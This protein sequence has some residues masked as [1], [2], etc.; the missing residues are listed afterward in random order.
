VSGLEVDLVAE[1]GT[2]EGEPFRLR[3]SFRTGG[4]ITVVFGPSGAGKSTLLLSVLGALRPRSGRI[5]LD[6]RVL[7][8]AAA[9]VDLPVRR[10]RIGVVFQDALLFPHLDA[11]AN[12]AFGLEGPERWRL[13]DE[14]LGRVDGSSLAR[15]RP[16]EMSGGERQRVAVARALAPRPDALLLDEPFSAL[17]GP[18]RAAL[19][20]LLRSLQAE[21]GIPFLHVTHDPVEALRLGSEMVVLERGAVA[22]VGPPGPVLGA[23]RWTEGDNLF[24]GVVLRHLEA[25]GY[26]SVDLGGTVVETALLAAPPGE[27]VVLRLAPEDILLS[28]RAVRETS[29][30]NVIA[31]RVE[32]LRPHAAGVEVRV[33]TPVVFR[34][35]LT[36]G[37]IRELGLAPGAPVHL[38]VKAY[39]FRS[40]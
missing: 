7:F 27:R 19:G 22:Q 34:A 24:A 4:G 9:R 35:L 12:V 5:A 40:A 10:R 1:R 31:G 8:D 15:R 20:S 18:S 36:H 13:A 25:E 23:A 38:L 39:S 32:E 3:V 2:Q 29:A 14:V 21:S 11:R 17:D 30:R 26:T 33:S 37:A 16:A 6:G 28:L